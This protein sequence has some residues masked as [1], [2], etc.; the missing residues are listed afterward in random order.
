MATLYIGTFQLVEVTHCTNAASAFTDGT[1][2]TVQKDYYAFNNTRT[3]LY[4]KNFLTM[5][6][7]ASRVILAI[8]LV[9]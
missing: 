4:I 1:T 3:S 9:R 2:F 5:D 8:K 6:L 7:P